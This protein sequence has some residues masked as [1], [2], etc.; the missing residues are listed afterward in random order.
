MI[1]SNNLPT[2]H[3]SLNMNMKSSWC[4]SVSGTYKVTLISQKQPRPVNS[5]GKTSMK[6]PLCRLLCVSV[7]CFAFE[8]RTSCSVCIR[9]QP[10]PPLSLC[11]STSVFLSKESIGKQTHAHIHT[12]EDTMPCRVIAASG[13]CTFL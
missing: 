1:R 11:V 7:C 10:L 3:P 9:Q 5:D 12:Q 13:R 2:Q 8:L 6:R 4:V